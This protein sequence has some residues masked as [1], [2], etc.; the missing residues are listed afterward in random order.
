ML[1]CSTLS[2]LSADNHWF[3]VLSSKGDINGQK[4]SKAIHTSLQEV[5]RLISFQEEMT[6]HMAERSAICMVV[7][8]LEKDPCKAFAYLKGIKYINIW[9]RTMPEKNL[10]ELLSFVVYLPTTVS[11]NVQASA[12]V[13]GLTD[14]DFVVYYELDNWKQRHTCRGFRKIFSPMCIRAYHAFLGLH[15]AMTHHIC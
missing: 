9:N 15:L 14:M 11:G 8:L 13:R 5:H 1:Y 2:L 7:S 3:V 12:R 6:V 4:M 10:V